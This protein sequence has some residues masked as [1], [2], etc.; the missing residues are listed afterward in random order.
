MIYPW[1]EVMD[2]FTKTFDLP[3]N[4]KPFALISLGYAATKI[5]RPSRY[6]ES[7]VHYN[8]W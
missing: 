7:L 8:K 2:N 1:V 6:N 4:I 5:E 3:E